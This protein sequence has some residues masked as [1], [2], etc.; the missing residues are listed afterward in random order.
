MNAT[1]DEI[2]A[3]AM[4]ANVHDFIMSLPDVLRFLDLNE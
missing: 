3:A 1:F 2:Q 4:T